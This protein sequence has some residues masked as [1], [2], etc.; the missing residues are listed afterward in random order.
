M[1]SPF[2]LQIQPKLRSALFNL[3]LLLSEQQ[4]P[5]EAMMFLKDLL[6]VKRF[7][8]F[9]IMYDAS[10]NVKYWVTTSAYIKCGEQ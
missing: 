10:H 5:M 8:E 1:C 2:F 6:K 4:R 3:A 9:T 7:E